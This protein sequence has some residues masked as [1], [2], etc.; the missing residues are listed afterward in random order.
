MG[1]VAGNSEEVSRGVTEGL[2][3]VITASLALVPVLSSALSLLLP[4]EAEV[5]GEHLFRLY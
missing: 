1:G 4:S 2:E 3:K 5:Q